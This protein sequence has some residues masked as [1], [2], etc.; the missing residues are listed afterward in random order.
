MQ[1]VKA[2]LDRDYPAVMDVGMATVDVRDVA[3]MYVKAMTAPA[4]PGKR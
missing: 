4:A 2:M 3:A 1:L